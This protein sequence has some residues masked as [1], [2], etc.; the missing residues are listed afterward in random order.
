MENSATKE[1]FQ[2]LSTHQ[3]DR[4]ND[5]IMGSINIKPKELKWSE[6][7]FMK[8]ITLDLIMSL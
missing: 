1:Q 6:K 3:G 8:G 2:V 7:R 5:I 4:A